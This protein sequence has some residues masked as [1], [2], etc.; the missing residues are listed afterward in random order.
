MVDMSEK[1]AQDVSKLVMTTLI[2]GISRIFTS[3]CASKTGP[4]TTKLDTDDTGIRFSIHLDNQ[5]NK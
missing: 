1:V 3:P 4:V 2:E 5:E